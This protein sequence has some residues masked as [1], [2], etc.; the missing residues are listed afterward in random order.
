VTDIADCQ[1]AL[2]AAFTLAGAV[3]CWQVSL[4]IPVDTLRHLRCP[5]CGGEGHTLVSTGPEPTD[6]YPDPCD[7]CPDWADGQWRPP[8]ASWKGHR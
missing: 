1:A 7:L 8:N 3:A 4:T 5:K 2:D 6:C